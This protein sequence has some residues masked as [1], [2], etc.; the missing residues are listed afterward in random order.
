MWKRILVP[1]DFSPSA[2]QAAALARDEAIAHGGEIMLLH[3][4][5]LPAAYGSETLVVS[6]GGEL[7][8][9]MADY[10]VR[11]ATEHLRS[12]AARLEAEQVA[13]STFVRLGRAVEEILRFAGEH[14]ADVIVMGTHGRTGLQHLISGS[15][16]ERVVR[17]SPVP[18]LTI[19]ARHVHDGAA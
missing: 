12:L 9:G 10:A 8:V 3:A 11:A 4:I 16:A 17:A 6:S 5:E 1:H 15:V 2:N 19:R 18:V 14:E 13:V 7:P